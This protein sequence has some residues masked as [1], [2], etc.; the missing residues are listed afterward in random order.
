MYIVNDEDICPIPRTGLADE[1]GVDVED[2][3]DE[4]CNQI[5]GQEDQGFQGINYRSEPFGHRFANDE[6]QYKVYSS[7]VHGDPNT[8]V[9]RAYTDDP[10]VLRVS[11]P[12]DR[13][14]GITFNLANHQWRQRNIPEAPLIG[15]QSDIS[16]NAARDL[17]LEGGAGGAISDAGDYIYQECKTKFYLEGG[18][19]GLMRVRNTT[20]QF[21]QPVLPLPDRTADFT[22]DTES[23]NSLAFG[24]DSSSDSDSEQ[25]T[26]V[27]PLRGSNED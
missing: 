1:E 25:L 21:D 12:A 18:L 7:K 17:V 8:P 6:R 20:E 16:T 23:R 13:A 24:S 15:T 19:W 3:L 10:V 11:Q 27:D 26:M 4:P 22:D 14:N 9:F 5:V 2:L